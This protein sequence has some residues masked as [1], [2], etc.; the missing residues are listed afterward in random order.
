MMTSYEISTKQGCV[1]PDAESLPEVS[2]PHTVEEHFMFGE[3]NC[4]IPSR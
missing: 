1:A 3:A 4:L 2:N